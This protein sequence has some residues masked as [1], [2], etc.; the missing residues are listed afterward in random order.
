MRM[1]QQQNSNHNLM[2]PNRGLPTVRPLDSTDRKVEDDE[3]F[4][5]ID[6]SPGRDSI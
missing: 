1:H 4:K 6:F 5:I 2:S 3:S